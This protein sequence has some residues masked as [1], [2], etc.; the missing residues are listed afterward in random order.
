MQPIIGMFTEINNE[1]DTRIQYQYA[2]ILE[3]G[4]GLPILFPYTEK[5][6]TLEKFIA[7]CDGFVFTGGADVNPNRYG[8]EKKPTCGEIQY[9]R[10]EVE[11][12]AF[13][14]VIQTAKPILAIC[15][16]MQLVNVALGG[17]LFQD[18][19]SERPSDMLHRDKAQKYELS[20]D[21]QILENT[22][23]S[24]LIK[25]PRM[26]ANSFHHQ[27]VKR[28]AQ[29]LEIMAV[30]DDGVIEAVYAPDRTFL[31]AYQWHPERLAEKDKQNALIFEEFVEACRNIKN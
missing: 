14:K 4:G 15:R 23:L 13:K 9:Y 25:A 20:H 18:L 7:F 11:F 27:A 5:E 28:L 26:Q 10:D 29:G 17:T 24:T 1:K 16:G 22:P 12:A 19:D 6:A 8:E 21:V 2:K 3:D 30:A 31:R